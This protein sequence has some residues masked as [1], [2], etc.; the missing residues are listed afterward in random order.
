MSWPVG[1]T[2]QALTALQWR[3]L[4]PPG[5]SQRKHFDEQALAPSYQPSCGASS[6]AEYAC[7][8]SQKAMFVAGV[9]KH[10][11]LMQNCC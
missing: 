11:R 9:N 6:W 8:N 5:S 2:R 10:C 3:S 7:R 4:L 1:M